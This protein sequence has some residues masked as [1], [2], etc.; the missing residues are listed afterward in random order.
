MQ[1]HGE[2]GAPDFYIEG[3]RGA[4]KG[5]GSGMIRRPLVSASA[6]MTSPWPE[7]GQAGGLGCW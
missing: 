2:T 1:G 6:R 7:M 4:R 5:A 3:R